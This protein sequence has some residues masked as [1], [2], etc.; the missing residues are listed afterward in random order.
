M[1][2]FLINVLYIN[3]LSLRNESFFV[4]WMVIFNYTDINRCARNKN[5]NIQNFTHFYKEHN[6]SN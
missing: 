1:D 2:K 4:C 5:L 3:N 6:S